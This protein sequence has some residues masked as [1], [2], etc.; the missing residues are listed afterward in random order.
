[1][2]MCYICC[3]CSPLSVYAVLCMV[4][5]F[6]ATCLDPLCS[7]HGAC[8]SGTCHCF[9][10]HTGYDC[11]LPT[12][13]NVTVC[14]KDCSGHGTFHFHNQVCVCDPGWFGVDCQLGR[15]CI[16]THFLVIEFMY[17]HPVSS[18]VSKNLILSPSF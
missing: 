8:L 4:A 14:V 15:S 2:C 12:P 11:S 9:S 6:S 16:I 3:T 7:G 18:F 13:S 1:M 17:C 10:G 5:V